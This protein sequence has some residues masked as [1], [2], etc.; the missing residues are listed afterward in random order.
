MELEVLENEECSR[1]AATTTKAT[2]SK[3]KLIVAE[4]IALGRVAWPAIQMFTY[5]IGGPL[6]WISFVSS[7][8]LSYFLQALKVWF[9]GYWASQYTKGAHEPAAR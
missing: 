6:F 8:T 1:D 2:S 5:S 9:L 4:E 7:M 3:G